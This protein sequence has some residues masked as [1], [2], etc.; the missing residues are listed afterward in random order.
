MSTEPAT[1]LG[2]DESGLEWMVTDYGGVVHVATRRGGGT[3]SAPVECRDVDA[4]AVA[5]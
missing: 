1:Y 3:W 5:S 2:T 4:R